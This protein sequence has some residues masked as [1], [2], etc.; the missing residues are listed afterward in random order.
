VKRK[1]QKKIWESNHGVNLKNLANKSE[2][3]RVMIA[4]GMLPDF[5]HIP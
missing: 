4:L 5:P 3:D 2:L 1:I